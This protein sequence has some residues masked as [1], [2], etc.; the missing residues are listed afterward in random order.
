MTNSRYRDWK[1]WSKFNKKG[2]IH[3]V[4]VL[5]GVIRSPTFEVFH[6]RRRY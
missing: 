2:V 3:N 6:A 5:F 1:I 4:L